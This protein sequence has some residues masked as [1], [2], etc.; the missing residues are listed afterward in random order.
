MYFYPQLSEQAKLEFAQAG[1]PFKQKIV[2]NRTINWRRTKDGLAWRGDIY[3][4]HE[5]G[6]GSSKKAT[7]SQL[8]LVLENGSL[9][10]KMTDKA[11]LDYFQMSARIVT[12]INK[13]KDVQHL[14]FKLP[15]HGNRMPQT[16]AMKCFPG[17]ELFN[18]IDHDFKHPKDISLKLSYEVSIKMLQAWENEVDNNNLIHRDIKSEN[19]VILIDLKNQKVLSCHMIDFD[20]SNKQTEEVRNS[21]GSMLYIAPEIL[22]EEKASTLSDAFGFGKILTVWWRGEIPDIDIEYDKN[23][24]LEIWKLD[25]NG[26]MIRRI[27]LEE[28]CQPRRL[29]AGLDEMSEDEQDEMEYIIKS[30]MNINTQERSSIYQAHELLEERRLLDALES[31]PIS[32][33][34]YTLLLGANHYGSAVNF[35][36][37]NA[38]RTGLRQQEQ[39]VR[40]IYAPVIALIMDDKLPD[41]ALTIKEFVTVLDIPQFQEAR[42]KKEIIDTLNNIISSY[43]QHL[44]QLQAL[45]EEIK[46]LQQTPRNFDVGDELFKLKHATEIRLQ[47]NADHHHGID[48]LMMF[49]RKFQKM[50]ER[51]NKGLEGIRCV[52]EKKNPSLTGG[53]G[54]INLGLFTAPSV[55]NQ[56]NPPSEIKSPFNQKNTG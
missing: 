45:L 34:D 15:A 50:I 35:A 14:D 54:Q 22:R 47:R 19:I 36:L 30:L 13:S 40:A 52:D 16:I 38:I 1:I 8:C 24:K 51:V 27:S 23:D 21:C 12:E 46:F 9:K 18:L 56:T 3:T 41:Q 44:K 55:P 43:E 11:L 25:K 20:Y 28:Y 32:D 37:H 29:F 53:S 48:H 2:F 33:A 7:L 49:D 4:G 31:Q 10:T 26:K 42:S 39:D 6:E 17:V 5:L